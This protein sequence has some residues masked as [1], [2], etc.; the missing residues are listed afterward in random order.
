M[1]CPDRIAAHILQQIKLMPQRRDT[2]GSAERPEVV[3]IADTF[4]FSV[5]PVQIKSFLRDEL[6]GADAET[7]LVLIIHLASYNN[8]GQCLIKM[9]MLRRPKLWRLH[10]EFLNMFVPLMVQ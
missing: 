5:L 8:L 1:G 4:E 7:R 10:G 9:R 6:D 3:V 2:Y